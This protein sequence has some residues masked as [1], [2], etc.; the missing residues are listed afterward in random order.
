MGING[1][2]RHA[3]EAEVEFWDWRVGESCGG[4][5]GKKERSEAGVYMKR[6]LLSESE[7][8]EGGDIVDD[9]VRERRR[10]ADE[11]DGVV[12]YETRNGCEGRGEVWRW[13][14]YDVEFDREV[15]RCFMKGGVGA[16][17]DDHLWG[18]DSPF[19]IRFLTGGEACHQDAF[20][21][22]RGSDACCG[23]RRAEE[24]EDHCHDLGFHFADTGKDVWVNGVCDGEFGEGV[25][26]EVDDV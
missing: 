18:G 2:A 3:L 17:G 23:G 26:L 6:D 8:A 9:A 24:A 16:H 22:A 7:F 12:V 25:S 5:E 15:F 1:N 13:T 21:A 11:E 4:E 10:G 19:G 14:I 20:C